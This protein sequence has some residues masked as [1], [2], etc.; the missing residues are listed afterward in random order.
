MS[1]LFLRRHRPF[2]GLL[3]LICA[4]LACTP[5]TNYPKKEKRDEIHFGQG[6]GFTGAVT[7]YILLE[8]GRLFQQKWK[9]TTKTYID[10]WPG[11]FTR[12]MF[13]NY[14]SLKIDTIQHNEPGD[15]YYFLE[16]HSRKKEPHRIV[17]GRPGFQA[18]DNLITYYNLLYKSVKPKS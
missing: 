12:Q 10:T 14:K 6:G 17:W 13:L 7:H 5:S 9:D 11:I 2:I 8:D 15:L 1:K 3:I 16:Y 4:V 18:E